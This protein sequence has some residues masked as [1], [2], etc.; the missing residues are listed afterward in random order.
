MTENLTKATFLEKVFNFER[1]KVF[2]DPRLI[3][4]YSWLKGKYTNQK[5]YDVLISED[6]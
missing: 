3:M 4:F 1:E 6:S 2:R 5:T